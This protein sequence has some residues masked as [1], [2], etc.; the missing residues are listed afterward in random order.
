MNAGYTTNA[1]GLCAGH[2]IGVRSIGFVLHKV[3]VSGAPLRRASTSSSRALWRT[4]RRLGGLPQKKTNLAERASDLRY[5]YDHRLFLGQYCRVIVG[6][7]PRQ[8][9]VTF[10]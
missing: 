6:G 2:P 8:E 5:S 9:I 4:C 7:R 1:W 10:L 3:V